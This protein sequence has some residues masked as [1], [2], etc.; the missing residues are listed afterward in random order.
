MT[1]AALDVADEVLVVGSADPVGLSRLA[2]AL[3]E[4]RDVRRRRPRHVVVNRMRPT[5]G[6]SEQDVVGWSRGSPRL[7]R[8]HFLP[9]D[10]AAVDRA[11][12]AGARWSR[13]GLA[14]R[15]R[16]RGRGRRA[17]ARGN[18]STGPGPGPPAATARLTAVPLRRRVRRRTAGRAPDGEA[19]IANSSGS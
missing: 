19:I 5:L 16:A 12:V 11:L 7:G 14:D 1:L 8:L 10:R 2:R 18:D 6:W 17:G 3:V 4:L 9:E 15:A 13:R